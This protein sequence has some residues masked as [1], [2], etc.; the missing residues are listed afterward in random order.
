MVG[1]QAH[2]IHADLPAGLPPAAYVFDIGESD[3]D[4]RRNS[5][6]A[7]NGSRIWPAVLCRNRLTLSGVERTRA[8]GEN[9]N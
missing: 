5:F 3:L 2:L 4:N 1:S 9:H 8:I 7:I 6:A